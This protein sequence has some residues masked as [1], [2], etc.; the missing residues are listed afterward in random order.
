MKIFCELGYLST[1][2]LKWVAKIKRLHLSHTVPL[3]LYLSSMGSTK[4]QI[5]CLPQ[6]S[7]T[8]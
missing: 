6:M 5:F 2:G 3:H 1:F 4:F 8:F 7:F